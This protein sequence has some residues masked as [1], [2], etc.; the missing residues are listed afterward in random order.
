M[1]TPIYRTSAGAPRR[2]AGIELMGIALLL[3]LLLA[4]FLP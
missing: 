4:V 1:A 3:L 2:H